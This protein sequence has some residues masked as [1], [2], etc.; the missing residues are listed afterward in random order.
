LTRAKSSSRLLNAPQ[1]FWMMLQAILE[2]VFVG[3]KPNQNAGRATVPRDHD[4]LLGREAK[5]PRQIIL[6]FR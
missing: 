6:Y 2:P 1:E 4:L 5:I 3:R